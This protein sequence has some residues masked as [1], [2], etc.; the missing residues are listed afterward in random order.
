MMKHNSKLLPLVSACLMGMATLANAQETPKYADLF[1]DAEEYRNSDPL[2]FMQWHLENTGQSAEADNGGDEGNDVN[3]FG[4]HFTYRVLGE[5]VNVAVV[6]SGL[7]I[8]HEDFEG[9]ILPGRSRNYVD[10]ASDPTDP[11]PPSSEEGGDHG[12]SVAGLIA[13]RGFNE[14]GGRGVAPLAKLMGFNWLENQSSEGWLETHGGEGVTDDALVINQSYGF[15]PIWPVNF[16]SIDN[17]TEENHLADVTTD[18]NNGRGIVFVKSAG[19]SFRYLRNVASVFKFEIEGASSGSLPW[20]CSWVPSN[21]QCQASSTY[22][23]DF[24]FSADSRDSNKTQ[25]NSLPAQIA[26]TEPSNASFYHTT[27]SALSAAESEDENGNKTGDLISSYS[28]VG[29]S[30]WISAHGGEFG[31]ANP[32]MV[33]TDIEGCASGYARNGQDTDFNDSS[34]PDNP[35]C[36][37]TSTFNG[38]SSAAPVASGVFALVFDANPNLT[39]RDAKDILAKTATKVGENF[40]PITVETGSGEFVAEPGWLKNAAGYDFHNWYGF[41]RAD[42]TAAVEMALSDDY[43][44]LPVL[45][46]TDFVEFTGSDATIPEGPEGVSQSLTIT[47]ALTVEAVQVKLS[48]RHGRDADLAVELISP[49][50]TSSMVVTPRSMLVLDQGTPVESDLQDALETQTDFNDTVLLSNA[51]YGEAAQ[52]NWTLKVTDTNSGEFVFYGY[53]RDDTDG[54]PFEEIRTANNTSLGQLVDWSVRIYGH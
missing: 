3:T 2:Y 16:D 53:R 4:A 30:V 9:N 14:K 12:T 50:G 48:I 52:G 25:V 43:Q 47:D 27:I 36:N 1:S 11:T 44:P 26:A 5:S 51:F 10:G 37:Y 23:P 54:D 17:L 29:S 40:E 20:W 21:P 22:V 33:T 24:I 28:T 18:A 46:I 8:N 6:D 7:A 38:T 45:Q 19:N 31:D 35:D 41:G 49:A 15:S 13:A 39:W 32:A 42:A 34:H